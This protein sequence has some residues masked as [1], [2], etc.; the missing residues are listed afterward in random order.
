MTDFLVRREGMLR[1]RDHEEIAS[2][3]ALAFPSHAEGYRGSTSWAG[4]QPEVRITAHDDAGVTAH[5]GLKRLYVQIGDG[6]FAEDQLVAAVG[7]VAVR[8][9]LQ[10]S[11]LGGRLADAVRSVLGQLKVP[12]GLLETG[13]DVTGFYVRHGWHALPAAVGTYNAFTLHG[14]AR[15]V[16]QAHG[17]HVLP[18]TADIEDWPEGEIHWNGQMV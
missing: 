14:P 17:W 13:E 4:L 10:G 3:L 1:L 7:M 9:D 8:P 11:G 6:P 18:V 16:R 2:T 12:F 15:V 5:A